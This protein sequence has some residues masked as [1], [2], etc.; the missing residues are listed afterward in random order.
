MGIPAEDVVVYYRDYL[1]KMKVFVYRHG[2][3]MRFNGSLS[4]ALRQYLN[5]DT[6]FVTIGGEDYYSQEREHW[7]LASNILVLDKSKILAYSHN[8]ITNKLVTEAGVRVVTFEGHEIIKEGGERSGPR[9]MSLP[10]IKY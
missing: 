3:T 2:E 9:C 10:L 4:G 8:R 6:R 7:L 5:P 1:E